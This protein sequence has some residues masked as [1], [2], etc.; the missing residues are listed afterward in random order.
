[1]IQ[2]AITGLIFVEPLLLVIAACFERYRRLTWVTLEEVDHKAQ[3]FENTVL[4]IPC[5]VMIVVG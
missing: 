1:M 5:S 2:L 3:R 4:K